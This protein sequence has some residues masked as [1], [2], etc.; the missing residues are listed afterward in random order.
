MREICTSGSMR[1]SDRPAARPLSLHSTLPP[2]ARAIWLRLRRAKLSADQFLSSADRS[3]RLRFRQTVAKSKRSCATRPPSFFHGWLPHLRLPASPSFFGPGHR[4]IP[5]NPP[6]RLD[7]PYRRRVLRLRSRGPGP[8]RFPRRR[9]LLQ[10]ANKRRPLPPARNRRGPGIRHKRHP[11][12][13]RPLQQNF[14][15]RNPE[16]PSLPIRRMRSRL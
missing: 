5:R 10:I 11:S 6:R 7:P 12:R 9:R 8:R 3:F 13:L 16:L 15:R 14:R 2:F 1:G 4:P